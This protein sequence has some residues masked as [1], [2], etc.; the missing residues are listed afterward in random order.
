MLQ[1]PSADLL[2][3]FVARALR[4]LM[5]K[6]SVNSKSDSEDGYYLFDECCNGMVSLVPDLLEIEIIDRYFVVEL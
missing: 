5:R 2:S 4:S 6:N 3:N 1:P